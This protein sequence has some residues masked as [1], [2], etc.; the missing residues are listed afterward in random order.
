MTRD[1]LKIRSS[2]WQCI[3][4]TLE[5]PTGFTPQCCQNLDLLLGCAADS[6]M[7]LAARLPPPLICSSIGQVLQLAAQHDDVHAS[8]GLHPW[9]V[10]ARSEQWLQTLRGLL[11]ENRDAGIGEVR[12][13]LVSH[14]C[15][16][17]DVIASAPRHDA[18][19]VCTRRLQLWSRR[20][21]SVTTHLN[22]RC[23]SGHG[24]NHQRLRQHRHCAQCGL[25]KASAGRSGS[26]D[27]LDAQEEVFR[28]QLV[29]A[30]ELARP[31]TVRSSC[32]HVPVLWI[33]PSHSVDLKQADMGWTPA[34]IICSQVLRHA[35]CCAPVPYG[36]RACLS[37]GITA[38]LL[39]YT[40]CTFLMRARLHIPALV[41]I[42]AYESGVLSAPP[43]MVT[44]AQV[45]CVQAYGRLL[46]VLQQLGPFSAGLV[47]HSWAGSPDMTHQLAAIDGVYFSVSGHLTRLRPAKARAT[48][49]AVR[50]NG[51]F[52]L[53]S[54]RSACCVVGCI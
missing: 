26:A 49:A 30:K 20:S 31:V 47:L 36:I 16:V 29:L 42:R 51:V 2:Q 35:G 9:K 13:L 50:A 24:L 8:L 41:G 37:S 18:R 46:A 38:G 21:N 43:D 45:H 11:V 19:Q 52:P 53:M 22:S 54:P 17:F 5:M 4:R 3:Q 32:L 28:Q 27:G 33:C 39:A 1:D 44:L 40:P 23:V 15:T 6:R 34:G 25:D 12:G 10:A 48:V 7:S 14:C